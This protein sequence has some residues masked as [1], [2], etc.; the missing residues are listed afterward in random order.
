[1]ALRNAVSACTRSPF[2][3]QGDAEIIFNLRILRVKFRGAAQGVERLVIFF[4]AEFQVAERRKI[5]GVVGILRDGGGLMCFSASS[6]LPCSISIAARLPR[7]SGLFSS[8][9]KIF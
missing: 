9:C 7:T 2:V 6:S 3:A 8:R 5:V 1:M 4:L